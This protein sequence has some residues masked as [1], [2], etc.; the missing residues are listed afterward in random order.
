LID[1]PQLKDLEKIQT[2]VYKANDAFTIDLEGYKMVKIITT[3]YD[4][5]NQDATT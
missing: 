5:I 4:C 3:V 1:H 2:Y